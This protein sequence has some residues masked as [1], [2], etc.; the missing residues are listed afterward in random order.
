MAHIL[1]VDDN[2]SLRTALNLML[3]HEGHSAVLVEDGRAGV[4]AIQNEDF[5]VLIVDI[6]MPE[7]DGFEVISLMRAHKPSLPII[8][9]SGSA[10]SSPD[11]L[12]MT[13]KLGATCRLRKPFRQADLHQAL[14]ACLPASRL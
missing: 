6:F 13:T 14:A 5:D 2:P 4:E 10:T 1:V 8:A 11:F 9:I 3:Q 7:M 12:A